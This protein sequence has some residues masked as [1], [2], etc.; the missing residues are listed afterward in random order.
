MHEAAA[1]ER[2]ALDS[3]VEVVRRHDTLL[4]FTRSSG[5]A[6]RVSPAAAELLPL[7]Q[8]G[9]E[10]VQL[11][12]RLQ[13][14][15]PTASDID[16]KLRAFLRTL[17]ASG[18]F[19]DT[20]ASLPSRGRR[21]LKFPLF[22]ADRVARLLAL[23]IRMLLPGSIG[24]GA[25]LV[26]VLVSILAIAML[27]K[28]DGLPRLG[29]L[30][31][32]LHWAGLLLFALVVVP[33][34]ELAHACTCRLVGIEAGQGGIILHGR[35]MPGPYIDTSQS[36]LITS[37]W[38]RFAIPAAGPFVNLLAA[39]VVAAFLTFGAP[40]AAY[41]PVLHTLLLACLLFV[42]FD[43]NPLT[44]SDGSHCIEAL[45]EDELARHHAMTPGKLAAGG[46]SKVARTYRICM[47]AHVA[48]S[49]VL[50]TFWI[51]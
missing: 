5:R 14:A 13:A 12:E 43:T 36:Y 31:Q 27:A 50:L 6:V 45:V 39:G 26:L 9:A 30:V 10:F 24:I 3:D 40:A 19:G 46:D 37:R 21:S 51:L 41:L 20:Q 35:F 15:H 38:K 23:P 22:A 49:A 42:Y 11:R 2:Y 29:Y 4:L 47:A 18:A 44:P 17:G 1:I 33:I 28:A 25:A 7:L 34:H 8:S 32:H 16:L 48:L